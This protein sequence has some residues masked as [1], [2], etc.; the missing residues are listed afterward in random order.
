[1][2]KEGSESERR[3]R[4][5][6]RMSQLLSE[7]LE[8]ERRYVQDLEQ[9]CDDYLTLT[10]E[11]PKCSSLD[12]RNL[13]KIKRRRSLIKSLPDTADRNFSA[14]MFDS[15]ASGMDVVGPSSIE[16]R[17][18]LGNIED[19]KDYH[20]RVMLPK[21]EEAVK[22][23]KLMR[24]LFQSEH[25]KLS[26]K[27]GRY[28]INNT[29]SSIIINQNIKFF[30]LYQFNK[31]LKLRVDGM[32][33]KPIQRLTRYHMFLSSL[34]KTCK[35]LGFVEASKHYSAALESVLSSASHTNT[36]M[37][38]GKMENCPVDLSGQGQLLKH[39]KLLTR[40]F[41]GS[42]KKGRKWRTSS[43]KPFSCHLFLFQQT[44]VL[45]RT[46]ENC[47]EQNNPHLYY[48]GHISVNQVRVRDTVGEDQNT[49]EVHKLENVKVSVMEE[50]NTSESKSDTKSGV[51]MRLECQSEEDKDDWV[52][53]INNE[54]KQLRSMAKTLSRQFIMII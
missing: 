22:D 27:Y 17:Q 7:L 12:R 26:R 29:R 25:P 45:C 37:W 54:V 32:L 46:S 51:I 14:D 38:I 21:M 1:M 19:I 41:A 18:M 35:E 9:V 15:M 4:H 50:P 16:I 10:G 48:A 11:H 23:V 39:G 49:F 5:E 42:V 36:M 33:I 44:V 2:E 43:Q 3:E 53:A 40:S 47:E 30:S 24:A 31:G 52:R 28:C 13:K 6:A 20:K 8:T 34:T